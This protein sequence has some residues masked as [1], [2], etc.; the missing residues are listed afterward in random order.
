MKPDRTEITEEHLTQF[1][2]A[3]GLASVAPGRVSNLILFELFGRMYTGTLDTLPAKIIHEMRA[4]EG[5]APPLGTLKQEAFSKKGILRGLYKKHYL[6][7]AGSSVPMNVSLELK[8]NPERLREIVMSQWNP[9]TADLA[10]EAVAARIANG[11]TGLY[12]ERKNRK[13]LTGE[14]IIYAKHG[15][16]NYYLTLA[17]HDE[18]DENILERVTDYCVGEFPWLAEQLSGAA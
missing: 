4:L 12:L 1:A 9:S 2:K 18:G 14:W 8:N 3:I 6:L 15:G 7:G 17:R 5:T 10:P 13:K 11:V 16:K